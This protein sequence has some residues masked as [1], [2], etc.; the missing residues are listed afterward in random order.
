[1][2]PAAVERVCVVAGSGAWPFYLA[3]GAW[4]GQENRRFGDAV[5]LGFYS[6]RQVQGLLPRILHVE[7][8]VPLT[9]EE[10]ATRAL[11][12]DLVQRRVGE[13]LAAA[14][15]DGT[16]SPRVAVVLLS[17]P[18]ADETVVI[19]ALAHDGEAAWTMFQRFVELDQLRA[20]T[21]TADLGTG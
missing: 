10:A 7:P 6:G 1:V 15:H 19:D 3:T 21:S 12:P 14:L 17:L 4:V 2:S 9:P 18:D 5:R 11:G 13:A 20:A 8:S 16:T